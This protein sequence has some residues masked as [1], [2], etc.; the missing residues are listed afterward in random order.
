MGNSPGLHSLQ[1][2]TVRHIKRIKRT[3]IFQGL[4]KEIARAKILLHSNAFQEFIK[5]QVKLEYN[6]KEDRHL[7]Q[8]L[9]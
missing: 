3:T 6:V 7:L 5:I 8:M 2:T 1:Y 9:I 4:F